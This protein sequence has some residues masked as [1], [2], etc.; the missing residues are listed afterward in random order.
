MSTGHADICI[1]TA[2][3]HVKSFAGEQC[4]HTDITDF[5]VVHIQ[6]NNCKLASDT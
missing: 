3:K 1:T 5:V 6:R 4:M 2:H